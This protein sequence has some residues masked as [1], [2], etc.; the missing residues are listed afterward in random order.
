MVFLKIKM[1]YP[2]LGD[3]KSA[4]MILN[5]TENFY[6]NIFNQKNFANMNF[7]LF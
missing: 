7:I 4:F 3:N 5:Y 1:K 6:Q 2:I